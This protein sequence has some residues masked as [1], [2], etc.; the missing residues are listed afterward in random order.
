M[1]NCLCVAYLQRTSRANGNV[2]LQLLREAIG[3]VAGNINEII[4]FAVDT[5]MKP[6]ILNQPIL[7]DTDLDL[8]SNTIGS[9]L[10]GIHSMYSS[11][12]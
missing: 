8:I 9:V 4:E 7:Q 2:E 3:M 1:T 5:I 10:A 11:K 6:Q 12:F